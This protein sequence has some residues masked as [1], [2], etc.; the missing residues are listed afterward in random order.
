MGK[1]LLSKSSY[2]KIL[3]SII[4][5]LVILYISHFIWLET[6][7]VHTSFKFDIFFIILVL[8]FALFYKISKYIVE[9]KTVKNCSKADIF[10]LALFFIFLF[11]PMSH[12]NQ[13]KISKAENRTL[14]KWHSIIENN[15]INYQFGKNFEKYFNDRFFLRKYTIAFNTFIKVNLNKYSVLNNGVFLNKKNNYFLITNFHKKAVR[16]I[17]K[18][19]L[20]LYKKLFRGFF[21]Y[22]KEANKECFVMIIPEKGTIYNDKIY[23]NIKQNVKQETEISGKIVKFYENN[24]IIYPIESILKNK[25]NA[26]LY[27]KN[28]HHMTDEG[29][30]LVFNE[31]LKRYN[32]VTNSDYRLL[33]KND[34]TIVTN[35][36]RR[37]LKDK[38]I[39][40]KGSSYM[41]FNYN[42]EKFLDKEYE[43]YF[44]KNGNSYIDKNVAVIGD[45]Y[46][47]QLVPFLTRTFS[48]FT[49]HSTLTMSSK[50][51]ECYFYKNIKKF[52]NNDVIILLVSTMNI[53]KILEILKKEK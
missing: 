25:N 40:T 11:I 52:E 22:C 13:D 7:G 18:N 47:G 41:A 9:F 12:I 43:H 42:N 10:F 32:K 4:F 28:D 39:Y 49:L 2:V 19:N 50:E 34:F 29:N 37:I 31:F 14:A 5:A 38:T 6:D 45:S 3:I 30:L 23:E 51:L 1:F 24:R 48:N 21:N 44:P 20:K 33:K 27:Y 36:K 46:I 26:L 53:D 17:S 16:N 35:T 15:K 8:S